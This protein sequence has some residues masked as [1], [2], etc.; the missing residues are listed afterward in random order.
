MKIHG[1]MTS[2]RAIMITA[3]ALVLGIVG[4]VAAAQQGS[5]APAD[6]SGHWT[7]YA[8]NPNGSSD[9]KTLDMKQSGNELSGHFKG[10][11]QA[12]GIEGSINGNHITLRTKTREIMR[13]WGTVDGDTI[14]GGFGIQGKH[15]EFEAKRT[16]E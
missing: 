15:G 8:R 12:G 5:N 6:V 16:S 4:S 10:P 11:N 3:A 1:S 2:C 13:F 7:I 9:T 14:R